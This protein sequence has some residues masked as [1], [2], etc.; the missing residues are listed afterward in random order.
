MNSLTFICVV[1][2]SLCIVGLMFF[3]EKQNTSI[4]W[5]TSELQN[6]SYDFNYTAP[7]QK[8]DLY[9]SLE[10]LSDC[11]QYCEVLNEPIAKR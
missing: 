8:C 6:K 3:M 10:N 1:V 4:E 7:A 5:L 9:M 2:F 11:Q